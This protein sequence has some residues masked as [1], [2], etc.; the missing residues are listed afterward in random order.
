MRPVGAP[1]HPIRRV[2]DQA[3]GERHRVMKWLAAGG[4]ALQA[5]DLDPAFL[6]AGLQIEQR[7]ERGI[8]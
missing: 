3:L 8:L 7:L 5:R 6:V 2:V 4:S 1:Q